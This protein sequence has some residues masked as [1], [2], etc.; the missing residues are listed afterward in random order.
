MRAFQ[1]PIRAGSP[2]IGQS[3]FAEPLLSDTSADAAPLLDVFGRRLAAL[4]DASGETVLLTTR[5]GDAVINLDVHESAQ[6]VRFSPVIG[7][8]KPMHSTAAGK[9]ML[10]KL[11]EEDLT[12]VLARLRLERHTESTITDR[13][14]LI[15]DIAKGRKRGWYC[16]VGENI[17]DLMS[18][19][20]PLAIGGEI[21]AVTIGGP[22]QRIK[23][24]M[25]THAERLLR[26]CAA[27]CRETGDGD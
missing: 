9:A 12:R 7:E 18:I 13:A 20:V 22:I 25:A 6:S 26:T 17:R 4:R 16:I 2:L 5:Q 3:Y 14:T 24:K 23:S 8:L 11:S 27:I 15:A 21:Y 10:G 19:A 1:P